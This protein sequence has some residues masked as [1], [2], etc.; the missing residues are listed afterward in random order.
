MVR[1]EVNLLHILNSFLIVAV[2][3]IPK[4]YLSALYDPQKAFLFLKALIFIK[5]PVPSC[6]AFSS[7]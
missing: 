2:A 5:Q 7:A 3:V 6:K 1:L 4:K